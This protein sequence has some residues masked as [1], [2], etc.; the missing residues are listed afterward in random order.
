[1]QKDAGWVGRG[2]VGWGGRRQNGADGGKGLR[3]SESGRRWGR[4]LRVEKYGK[5]GDVLHVIDTMT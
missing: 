4:E 5:E 2:G 1:M 3:V